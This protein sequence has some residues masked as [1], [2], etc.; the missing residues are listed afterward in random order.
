MSTFSEDIQARYAQVE[1]ETDKW[2]R[3]IK[4]RRLRPAEMNALR[5]LADTSVQS[6]VMEIM[7]ASMVRS[8]DG[9]PWPLPRSQ[10]DIDLVLN[11]LDDGMVAA[12]VAAARLMGWG[13][14]SDDEDGEKIDALQDEIKN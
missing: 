6:V 5:K 3:E 10:S 2:G 11:A 13:V 1:T 12:T 4:V 8:I 9:K 14:K 7:I